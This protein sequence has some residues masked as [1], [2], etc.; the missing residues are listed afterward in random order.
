MP[1]NARVQQLAPSPEALE[2]H[3]NLSRALNFANTE[4]TR[5]LKAS[6]GLKGKARKD[7]QKQ[8]TKLG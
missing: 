7:M 8:I 6:K 1:L 2:H 5:L 4:R 3:S